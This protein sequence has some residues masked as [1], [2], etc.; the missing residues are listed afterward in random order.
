[1]T[2]QQN[3]AVLDQ[4]H[5]WLSGANAIESGGERLE[6]VDG[7]RPYSWEEDAQVRYNLTELNEAFRDSVP[8]LGFA[9]W[10]I[11]RVG[12][13]V[14]ETVVPLNISSTNQYV[15]HQ[16]AVMLL[17]ADYTGGLALSTLFSSVPAIGFHSM[18]TDFGAYIW[19]AKATIK[20]I[21]PSC[22][23]LV[24]RSEIPEQNW[25]GIRQRFF[26]GEPVIETLQVKMFNQETLVGIA[27]FTYW[28]RNSHALCYSQDSNLKPH[29]LYEHKLKTS[30]L[31]IAGLRAMEQDKPSGSRS[32]NDPLAKQV[33]QQR[34]RVLAERFSE[35]MPQ[36]QTMVAARTRHLDEHLNSL[37]GC[38]HTIVNL[39]CGFDTRPWRLDLRRH[40]IFELD[41]P[42]MLKARDAQLPA[43]GA[44]AEHIKRVPID[45]RQQKL[46]DVLRAQPEFD[47]SMPILVIWEGGTM[48]FSE[49]TLIAVL[50]A[51]SRLLTHAKSHVWFDY[52]SHAAAT[53][54]TGL[55]RVEAFIRGMRRMG[56]PFVSGFKDVQ[57]FLPRCGLEVDRIQMSDAYI[58]NNDPTYSHYGFCLARRDQCPRK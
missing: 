49:P 31:L 50:E 33:A 36:L 11:T 17:A 43:C 10:E 12:L 47:P 24:C 51:I 13:G 2:Q 48:Y 3:Q 32:F 18:E 20:W 6:A 15:T 46:D 22:T 56:E 42:V 45:L 30:A 1:M 7:V 38:S 37:N 9:G 34:G 23:D 40:C 41:L 39:G 57:Q 16:A 58:Q 5:G 52:V 8:L 54:T 28:A 26:A 35:Y 14:T 4:P 27:D 55:P 53:N 21:A 19:A 44:D 29:V 25:E